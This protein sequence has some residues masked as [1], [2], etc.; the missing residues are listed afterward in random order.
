M[1]PRDAQVPESAGGSPQRRPAAQPA[2]IAGHV[3]RDTAAPP[4]GRAALPARPAALS[5]GP[6]L[7]ALLLA[8]RRR[9]L[10]AA[11]L[12]LLLAPAAAAGAWLLLAAKYT[13]FAQL[14]MAS[15]PPWLVARNVDTP[16]GRNEFVTFQKTQAARIKGRLVLSTALAQNEVKRLGLV[17][18]QADP[19]TWLEDELKVEYQEGNEIM[20]VSLAAGDPAEAIALVQAVVKAYYEQVV[21]LERDRRQE[22]VK[23]LKEIHAKT[24][25]QLR[26]DKQEL[27]KQAEKLSTLDKDAVAQQQM[28]LLADLTE[29]KRQHT[30]SSLE[31]KNAE[32]RLLTHKAQERAVKETAPSEAD[33]ASVIDAD[34]VGKG[35]Q[36]RVEKLR[37]VIKEYERGGGRSDEPTLVRAREQVGEAEKALEERRTA[38]Q[39]DLGKRLHSRAQ[40]DYD[41][42]LTQLQGEAESLTAQEQ[43]CA[44]R[45]Q[46]VGRQVVEVAAQLKKVG[47][48]PLELE[49]LRAQVDRET[50]Y[51]DKIWDELEILKAELGSP[52]RVTLLQDAALQKRDVKRQVM[53]TAAAPVAVLVL[54]ALAVALWEFRARR[55][56]TAEEVA[57]GLGIR[58]VGAVPPLRRQ[59]APHQQEEVVE[60]ID[61]IRTLLLHDANVEPARVVMVTSA[62]P[63]EGKTTLA[64]SLA[65]SLARAGRKTLL[66]DCDLRGPAAHQ[67]FE[68][69]LQPGFSEVLLGE[70]DAADAIQ[71]TP[72]PGLSLVTAGQWDREV[73][74]A[75]AREGTA[76]VFEK[77]KEEYEF[78]VVDS[79]P[80]LA[81]TD[82]LLLGQH[83]DAVLLSVLRD[84]SRS[85]RVYTAAQRLASLGVRVLGAVVNGA[86]AE[87]VYVSGGAAAVP[88]GR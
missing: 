61:A 13:A 17:Q 39:A 78:I 64:C 57:V 15:V 24:D 26:D 77:L 31:R 18:Q 42:L 53:A 29:A 69:P 71:A 2:P 1:L 88:A 82:S 43:A 28:L 34:P 32:R 58:V 20:T 80:V 11:A 45:V 8:L 81:A 62:V 36:A 6:D 21:N 54:A 83:V 73:L 50:K 70:I 33:V 9:W 74:R 59:A 56:R 87:D 27:R 25:K 5:S 49:M 46:E 63:G 85:P 51:S 76:E 37:Q 40:A 66:I 38:L 52:P 30:Q 67:V 19:I 44:Q 4:R 84:V 41:A 48:S 14:H 16:E 75:L 22:R 12:G 72:V 3:G 86:D 55:I 68:L 79:H 60:S 47:T 65:D 23:E 10:L 7:P 35:H